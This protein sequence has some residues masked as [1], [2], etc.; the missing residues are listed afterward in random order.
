MDIASFRISTE[1]QYGN[2]PEKLFQGGNSIQMIEPTKSSRPTLCSFPRAVEH[3]VLVHL[4]G[5]LLAIPG[6]SVWLE[7]E[8]LQTGLRVRRLDQF[9][10]RHGSRAGI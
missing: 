4:Y 9:S 2:V 3:L 6:S 5:P 10:G 1:F 7:D 8:L